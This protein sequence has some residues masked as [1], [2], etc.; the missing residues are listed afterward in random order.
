MAFPPPLESG[1]LH[2][3]QA[4][5]DEVT[6]ANSQDA[7]RVQYGPDNRKIPPEPLRPHDDVTAVD[8]PSSA[9]LFATAVGA[10]QHTLASPDGSVM[11]GILV[12]FTPPNWWGPASRYDVY[13]ADENDLPAN[14][15]IRVGAIPVDRIGK[16]QDHWVYH[17]FLIRGRTYTIAVVPVNADGAGIE[18]ESAPQATGVVLD[19]S[20]GQVPPDVAGFDVAQD[21]CDVRFT[22]TALTSTNND[23][24]YFEIRQGASYAAG[25]LVLRVFGWAVSRAHV[26]VDQIPNPLTAPDDEFHIKAVTT[27]DVESATEGSDTLTAEEITALGA[28]CCTITRRIPLVDGTDSIALTSVMPSLGNQVRLNVGGAAQD[29]TSPGMIGWVLDD[30]IVANGNLW[31]YTVYFGALAVSGDILYVTES[32]P[33]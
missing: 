31:D 9:D 6:I 15:F 19:G 4:D 21:C 27:L 26:S 2:L 7:T 12:G 3:R 28:P 25:T 23:V 17:P 11:H 24:A 10:A 18:P 33:R 8:T 20:G 13:A 14:C 16:G 32:I 30:S 1:E 22:W 5:L 29:V